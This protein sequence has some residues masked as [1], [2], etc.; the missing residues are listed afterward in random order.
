MSRPKADSCARPEFYSTRDIERITGFG[1][2]KAR[3]IMMEFERQKMTVHFG[4]SIVV[5]RELFDSYTAE[6]DGFDRVTGQRNFKLIKGRR[7]A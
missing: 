5:R 7:R 1:Y 6:Q 3:Q 4:R 2:T